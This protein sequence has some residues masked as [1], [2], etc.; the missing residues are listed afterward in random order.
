MKIINKKFL[1]ICGIVLFVLM[2][3]FLFIIPFLISDNT[4][5][6][7]ERMDSLM[8][9]Y[10]E[11]KKDRDTIED[12][13]TGVKITSD[14]N[15]ISKIK[16]IN[17]K[18]TNFKSPTLQ[19]NE[20]VLDKISENDYIIYK[21]DIFGV[22]NLKLSQ[23]S[24]ME[25]S[26][27]LPENFNEKNIKV[28]LGSSIQTSIIK[29]N[30][31]LIYVDDINDDIYV[32]NDTENTDEECVLSIDSL[33]LKYENILSVIVYTHTFSKN[34]DIKLL[35]Y[36]SDK[37]TFNVKNAD[38]VYDVKENIAKIENIKFQDID[39][40]FY[41]RL[42]TKQNKKEKYGKIVQYNI[43]Q[44][45]INLYNSTKDQKV[46]DLIL[47][48]VCYSQI[49]NDYIERKSDI[50][51]KFS[52]ATKNET[53]IDEQ[54]KKG[55]LNPVNLFSVEGDNPFYGRNV[56]M[57]NK[58]VYN[59]YLDTKYYNSIDNLKLKIVYGKTEKLLDFKLDDAYNFYKASFDEIQP[60][61]INTPLFISLVDKEG[62]QVGGKLTDSIG[63]FISQGME[64]YSLESDKRM[65]SASIFF[66]NVCD[67]Q[68]KM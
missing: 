53:T 19:S 54:I 47:G 65:F 20:T 27:P 52:L 35:F 42:Y 11:T 57:N 16:K 67:A 60:Y 5:A 37:E 41:I 3:I 33:S 23:K 45:C 63:T 28:F 36:K 29:N 30:N 8:Y 49:S 12:A 21:I 4:S 14:K 22:N 68:F 15:F 32:V 34:E 17:V 64:E 46:K 43:L 50:Y 55:V 10:Q 9:K 59:I 58:I 48:T 56:D 6:T 61:D 13:D 2:I 1:V 31:I 25:V 40:N 24:I 62:K 44:Y 26:I 39:D 7:D 18:K 38:M 66:M 51:S